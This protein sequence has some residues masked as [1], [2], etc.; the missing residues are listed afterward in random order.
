MSSSSESSTIIY[1]YKEPPIDSICS[2]LFYSTLDRSR[3][4]D[5]LACTQHTITPAFSK[6]ELQARNWIWYQTEKQACLYPRLPQ[7]MV[8][9]FVF[10]DKQD[11]K[12]TVAQL[13]WGG[14]L[15]Y[16]NLCYQLWGQDAYEREV[17]GDRRISEELR[18]AISTLFRVFPSRSY[19]KTTHQTQPDI[20]EDFLQTGWELETKT[21]RKLRTKSIPPDQMRNFLC[22][23]Y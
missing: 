12:I 3:V 7:D 10:E 6:D 1:V 17:E 14:S 13:I 16:P 23:F 5:G 19:K 21:W 15:K 8:P 20:P 9:W 11:R 2:G 18:V 22:G 4:P